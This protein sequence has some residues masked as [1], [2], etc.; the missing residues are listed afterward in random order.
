MTQL[1]I[2]GGFLGSGKT[3]AIIQACKSLMAQGRRVGVIT[4]DQG[5]YLV[6]TAFFRFAAG[7]EV[8]ALEVTGGCFCCNYDDLNGRLEQLI[9]AAQPEVI[10]A[11]SVGSCADLIATVIKPLLALSTATVKPCS[12]TV[13]T[14]IRLMRLLLMGEELPF[15]E[16]I[17]YIFEKQIEEAGLLVMNKQDLLPPDRVMQ[18]LEL[19]R[20]RYPAKEILTQRSLEPAGVAVWLE[21]LDQGKLAF[22]APTLEID[23]QKYGAGEADLAWLDQTIRLHGVGLRPAII[24]WIEALL[25]ALESARIPIGHLKLIVT[26]QGG[27]PAKISFTTPVLPGW[28]QQVPEIEGN[29]E[30]LLNG[31]VQMPAADLQELVSQHL[32]SA[33]NGHAIHIETENLAAFHPGFPRPTHRIVN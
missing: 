32:Q 24:R 23:Y 5:K 12:F 6:D 8:P 11:E 28:Q 9:A 15:S 13:F 10:F 16:N 25:A 26:P 19:A 27:A 29:V 31:R 1:H 4:N 18:L 20:Q 30:I 17:N 22:P 33:L 3:T 7:S 14:D 21:R 2:V